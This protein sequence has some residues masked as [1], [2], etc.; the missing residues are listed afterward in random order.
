MSHKN[1]Q[2]LEKIGKVLKYWCRIKIDESSWIES[3]SRETEWYVEQSRRFEFSFDQT[4]LNTVY[5]VLYREKHWQTESGAIPI[6]DEEL[7]AL[8]G[9]LKKHYDNRYKSCTVTIR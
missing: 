6:T 2:L 8:A 7:T 4:G 5:I 3:G 1:A 9:K